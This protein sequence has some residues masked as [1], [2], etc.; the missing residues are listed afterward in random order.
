MG[1]LRSAD[2]RIIGAIVPVPDIPDRKKAQD[3]LSLVRALIDRTTDGVEV[4]DP[5]TGRLSSM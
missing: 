5:E 2:A 4:L 3:S 1:P